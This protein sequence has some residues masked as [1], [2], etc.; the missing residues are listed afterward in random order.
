MTGL[1]NLERR[2][3][4]YTNNLSEALW[5]DLNIVDGQ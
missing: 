4:K 2:V 3:G 5:A 1:M